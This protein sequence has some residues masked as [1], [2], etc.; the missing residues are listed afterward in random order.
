MKLFDSIPIRRPKRNKFDL[1]HERKLTGKFGNLVPILCEEIMPGDSFTVKSEVFMRLAPMVAPIM[2]RVDVFTHYFWVP[3]RILWP[4]WEKF[5]TGGENGTDLPIAPY[6]TINEANKASYV[7]GLLPDYFGIPTTDGL[8]IAQPVNISALPFRAYQTIYREFYRDQNLEAPVAFPLTDG[9]QTASTT[10]LTSIRNRAFE[11]DYFTSALPWAQR[12]P[13]VT[14]PFSAEINYKPISIVYNA[15]GTIATP[16]K[17]LGI[18]SSGTGGS[19]TPGGLIVDRDTATTPATG[20]YGRIENIEDITNGS[21]TINDLRKSIR[22]QEWLE[23]NARG[24]ARYVEQLM[25]HFGVNPGDYTAQ[26]PV[27]L[28]GGKQPVTVSE[29]LASTETTDQA[30]GDMA[31]H[32]VSV[33]N[34]NGFK[35]S[36]REHGFVIGIMSVL[37]RTAYQQGIHKMWSRTDKLEYAWPEF[38]NLGEQEIKSKEIFADYTVAGTT[39]ESTFGYQ[40]RYAEYKYG[41]SSVHGQFRDTMDYWHLGRKFASRPV[42]NNTFV[43]MTPAEAVRVFAVQNPTVEQY[44]AQVYNKVDALRPLPYF[45]T[46]TL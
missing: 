4:N 20:K 23:K 11:K 6:L 35:H 28:G 1:S 19:N 34:T 44:Y 5:I 45:G 15:D 16:D 21:T 46:P 8:T 37:P 17:L 31:G 7:K 24:G 42:L 12:G 3:N 38:A 13:E 39:N 36:F 27:Y 18:D 22:L 30:L 10:L 9:D 32:G 26:R 25:S 40:S 29:V 43:K 33:G 41:K 14:M 2:H